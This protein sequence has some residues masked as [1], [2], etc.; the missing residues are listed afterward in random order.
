MIVLHAA[1]DG[2]TFPQWLT[3][4]RAIK[5]HWTPQIKQLWYRYGY[6]GSYAEAACK[7]FGISA[8]Y[9]NNAS[10]VVFEFTES[11]YTWFLMRWQ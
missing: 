10:G 6:A 1:I 11:Q 4:D 7:Y 9:R 3:V 5:K 2:G 8:I